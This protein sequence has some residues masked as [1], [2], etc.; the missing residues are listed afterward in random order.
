MNQQADAVM[1]VISNAVFRATGVRLRK[2]PFTSERLWQ[3][4]AER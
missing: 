1:P 2:S 4:L 3:A